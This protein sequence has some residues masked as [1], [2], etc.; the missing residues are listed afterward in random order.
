MAS[1]MYPPFN[2]QQLLAQAKSQVQQEISQGARPPT[3]Q[4]VGGRPPKT[5]QQQA[6][7]RAELQEKVVQACE[8]L[9]AYQKLSG[10]TPVPPCNNLD[11]KHYRDLHTLLHEYRNAMDVYC[12]RYGDPTWSERKASKKLAPYAHEIVNISFDRHKHI[13]ELIEMRKVIIC[14]Q[15][16]NG[17]TPDLPLELANFTPSHTDA[18]I[19]STH[20]QEAVNL[21]AWMA[22]DAETKSGPLLSLS[23]APPSAIPLHQS[24]AP[25][26]ATAAR[27]GAGGMRQSSGTA[28]ASPGFRI[29]ST[30][31]TASLATA[32]HVHQSSGP[33]GAHQGFR[34]QSTAPQGQGKGQGKGQGQRPPPREFG[35]PPQAAASPALSERDK[36]VAAFIMA[37]NE[38]IAIQMELKEETKQP[39]LVASQ[40][41]FS[42]EQ[43]DEQYSIQLQ[44]LGMWQQMLADA[45]AAAA[46]PPLVAAAP[47]T[48]AAAPPPLAA[49]PPP[50]AA[51]PQP[52]AASS[53]P[54]KSA[55]T[56]AKL[57][58]AAAASGVAKLAPA[59]AAAV[60]QPAA[61]ATPPAL[62]PKPA[63]AQE[64]Q[65]MKKQQQQMQEQQQK[66]QQQMQEQ[67]RQMQEQQQKQQQ[68]TLQALQQMQ[69]MMAA[70]QSFLPQHAAS[71]P[72]AS[73]TTHTQPANKSGDDADK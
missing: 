27:T 61:A 19:Q 67:Q 10:E 9:R 55:S 7:D 29:Q 52:L 62:L 18:L 21:Q 64:I 72:P 66:Q 50:L 30:G 44:S 8:E 11:A 49:A 3:F 58:P 54:S 17:T 43:L 37:N 33:A 4:G 24:S 15:K 68:E 14:Y 20:A 25:P 26:G 13:K 28:G 70:F 59:A 23:S 6:A 38:I 48:L 39:V 2:F 63:A 45:K 40:F 34:I 41:T 56:P 22:K 35:M 69:Q 31:P 46:P 32:S 65:E 1:P 47:P 57:A 60:A 12:L 16:R 36:K 5:P 71:A 73:A 53:P 51:A 42:D